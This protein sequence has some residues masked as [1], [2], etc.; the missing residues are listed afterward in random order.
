MAEIAGRTTFKMPVGVKISRLAL[1]QE[2][3]EYYLHRQPL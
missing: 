1:T 3:E 2:K